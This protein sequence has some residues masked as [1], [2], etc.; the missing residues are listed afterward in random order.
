MLQQIHNRLDAM[1]AAQEGR[2]NTEAGLLDRLD[3]LIGLFRRALGRKGGR[4]TLECAP[5]RRED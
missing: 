3:G 2:R 5:Q 1:Q 4:E